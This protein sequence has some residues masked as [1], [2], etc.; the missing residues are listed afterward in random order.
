[1]RPLVVG[2]GVSVELLSDGVA[3]VL[4]AAAEGLADLQQQQKQRLESANKLLK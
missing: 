3:D 1:M 2:A 4:A